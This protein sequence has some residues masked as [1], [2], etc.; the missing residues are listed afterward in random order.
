MRKVNRVECDSP[1][2]YISL[3]PILCLPG[4]TA[5]CKTQQNQLYNCNSGTTERQ[6]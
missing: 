6:L 1:L 3:L 2:I 5:K 4:K